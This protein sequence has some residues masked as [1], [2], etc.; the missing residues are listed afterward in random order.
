MTLPVRTLRRIPQERKLAGV[1]AGLARYAGV[2]PVLVR[3]GFVVLTFLGGSGLLIYL[4]AWVVMPKADPAEAF[5]GSAAPPPLDDP[6]PRRVG[7][8]H[9]RRVRRLVDRAP[10]RPAALLLI[11]GAVALLLQRDGRH[12]RPRDRPYLQLHGTAGR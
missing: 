7:L 12:R 3:L 1:C 4:V 10:Q 6:G 8:R 9:R 2:D 5:V 11:G